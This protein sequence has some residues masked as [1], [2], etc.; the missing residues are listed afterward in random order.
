MSRGCL[1]LCVSL[2][3][4]L[5][6]MAKAR[7]RVAIRVYRLVLSFVMSAADP[8]V[9]FE[10]IFSFSLVLPLTIMTNYYPIDPQGQR[11]T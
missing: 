11:K 7:P 1:R 2:S 3:P 10:V 4:G 8:W 5:L 6:I 9:D